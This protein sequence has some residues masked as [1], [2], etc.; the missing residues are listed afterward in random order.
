MNNER[1][2]VPR[3][4]ERRLAVR[5]TRDAER[6]LRSGHPWLF[7]RSITSLS[8]DG[9]S[10]DLAVV[11]DADRRFVAVGL[12]DPD[13]PIRVRILHQGRPATIDDTWWAERLAAAFDRRSSLETEGT[14][15]YRCVNG[16]SDGFG[17]LVLD[18]YDDVYVLKVYSSAWFPHLPDVVRQIDRLVHPR[19]LVLRL[20]RSVAERE[21]F[22]LEDPTALIGSLPDEPVRFTENGLVME[23]D[24]VR[25]QKTGHFL[26][27]RDNRRLVRDMASDARVLDVFACTG[28]FSLHAAAGGARSVLSVDSSAH[29]LETAERNMAANRHLPAVAAC[30][31]TTQTGDAFEVMRELG[32]R[33]ESFDLVIVDPPSFAHKA[34]DVDRAKAA[35]RALTMLALAL[36]RPGGRL[37]QSSCSSRL[38]SDDFVHLVLAAASDAGVDVDVET[39][40]AHAVDHPIGFAEA[41]YLKTVVLRRVG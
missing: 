31:H 11:F 36:V 7:D 34:S 25:G 9:V 33:H 3:P 1:W 23:A 4:S 17:G 35:Y 22:G 15:G 18:R 40:T 37:V 13:S 10:G 29:A 30:A 16:E 38:T 27:Q 24:V 19:S 20:A 28:G 41:E 6:R 5:V 14:T 39:R 21:C 8:H 26:D 12:F 2:G 32:R